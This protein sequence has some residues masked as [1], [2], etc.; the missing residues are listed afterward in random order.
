MLEILSEQDDTVKDEWHSTNRSFVRC[1]LE[2]LA[3]RLNI[4]LDKEEND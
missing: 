4:N 3:E 2:I 1:G